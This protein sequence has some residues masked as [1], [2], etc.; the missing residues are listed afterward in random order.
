MRRARRVISDPRLELTPLLDVMFLLLTFFI[1]AFVL[2]VRLEVTD[3]RLPTALAGKGVERAPSLT[4]SIRED[5]ALLVADQPTE[6]D[7]VTVSIDAARQ[8]A[9]NTQL[10]IAVDERA[11]AGA[12]FKLMDT[13]RAAG[14]SD[15]RF[16]RAPSATG[17]PAAPG[18]PPGAPVSAPEPTP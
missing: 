1:F 9:P 13:L 4:I 12:V 8:N 2:M 18:T 6:L 14:H 3:I 7:Q 5:G 15:L 10:F 17:S 16:L 11:P